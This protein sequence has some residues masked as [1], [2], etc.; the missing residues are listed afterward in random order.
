PRKSL[1]ASASTR[2]LRRRFTT[3]SNRARLSSLPTNRSCGAAAMPRF[4][5]AEWVTVGESLRSAASGGFPDR[6]FHSFAGK[7]R[8]RKPFLAQFFDALKKLVVVVRVMMREGQAL[9]AGHLRK[10]HGLI[11]AAVSPSTPLL[12]FLSRVLRVV[13]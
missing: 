7:H 9:H 5:K 1:R 2:N 10:L 11:E 12:Q 13:D 3:P 8:I 4:S 6:D